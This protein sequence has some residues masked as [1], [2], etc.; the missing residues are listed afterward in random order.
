[1]RGIW[2][3][4]IEPDRPGKRSWLETRLYSRTLADDVT[5]SDGTVRNLGPVVGKSLEDLTLEYLPEEH[6]IRM[7][8]K[9]AGREQELR[10][11]AGGIRLRG[12]WSEG[13]KAKAGDAFSYD[14][15]LWIAKG[16]TAGKPSATSGDWV[17]GA[18]Q[19]RPGDAARAAPAPRAG[20]VQLE[21]AK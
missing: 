1:M 14:G 15:S 13:V 16:E 4:G 18:R 10:Y 7:R 20:V 3:D 8:V 5:L 21:P 12:Y 17:L 2:I 9:C 6:Q 11:D 19:G